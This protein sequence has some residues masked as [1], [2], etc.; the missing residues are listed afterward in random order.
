MKE[1]LEEDLI[2]RINDGDE[3]AF[4]LVFDLYYRPLTLFAMKY[5]REV[6]DAK[7]IVQDFFVR[8]W[9][10][11]D[12]LEIRFSLRIYLYRSVRNACLN[13]IASDK[14]EKKRM[15][16]YQHP[17]ISNDNALEHMMAAEQEELLMRAIDNLPEKCRRIFVMSRMNRLSHQAIA[18][19]L[20]LSVKTVEAQISIALKRLAEWVITLVMFFCD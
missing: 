17:Q 11:R 8:M 1:N 9:S 19:Q 14:V 20:N 4:K 6:E 2:R 15:M 7:E 5:V 3:R 18:T 12:T 13:F 10:K 16:G